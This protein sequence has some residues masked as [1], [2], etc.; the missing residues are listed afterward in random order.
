MKVLLNIETGVSFFTAIYKRQYTA[1]VFVKDDVVYL[2]DV[3]STDYTPSGFAEGGKDQYLT[4][5]Y[6]CVGCP[7]SDAS[8]QM[9]MRKHLAVAA[10]HH[11]QQLNKGSGCEYQLSSRLRVSN[12]LAEYALAK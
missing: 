2:D 1:T 12:L 5:R 3:R 7:V 11:D 10:L 8:D 4:D 6:K 9:A